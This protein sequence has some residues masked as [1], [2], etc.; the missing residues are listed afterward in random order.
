[1]HIPQSPGAR[2]VRTVR[3]AGHLQHRYS[4]RQAP[5]FIIAVFHLAAVRL[6]CHAIPHHPRC[7]TTPPAGVRSACK[8]KIRL[9]AKSACFKTQLSHST[10]ECGDLKLCDSITSLTVH[11]SLFVCTIL[12]VTRDC[13][14]VLCFSIFSPAKN[15]VD[16]CLKNL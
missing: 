2:Q 15:L 12:K 11:I 9:L 5:S 7:Q 16:L 8:K 6:L 1:M 10:L 14:F 4:R 3:N 13:I